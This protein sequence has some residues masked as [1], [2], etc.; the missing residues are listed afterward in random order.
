MFFLLLLFVIAAISAIPFEYLLWDSV[1]FTHHMYSSN[2]MHK[3]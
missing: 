3:S 2:N 1:L